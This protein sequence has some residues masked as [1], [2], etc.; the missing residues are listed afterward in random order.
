MTAVA[1]PPIE[2][3]ARPEHNQTGVNFRRPM[4][5]PKVKGAV[6]DFHCHLFA[7]RHADVWFESADHY[8]IDR[9]VTMTPLEE[10]VSLQ[11][12]FGHRL[13]FIAVPRWQDRTERWV[14]E[15]RLRIEAFYNLG[16]R[17]VK[18]H[19][20]PG[21]MNLRGHRLDSPVYKP[22]FRE[23]IDRKMAIMTHIGDPELWYAGKYSDASKFG[24]RDEHY[25]MWD[26]LLSEYAG[27]PW[28]GAHL[29]GNP[30]NFTRLQNLLDR[31]PNL[32]L[33]C[34][35][36]RWMSREV[37]AR[38][39]AAR[40]FFIRNQDRI[41]FGSDQVSG[42]DRGFDFLSS[43]FWVHRKLW[44]TAFIGQTPILDPDLPKDQQPALRGLALPDEVLQ[45]IYHDNATRLLDAIRMGW[46]EL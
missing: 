42:D 18:F 28:V 33:D 43:R 7:R 32:M 41:L 9:F 1:P 23:V 30:E 4:P 20:A 8:G 26:S 16:S 39:D 14:D 13:R 25:R 34:S 44:E 12:D 46:G 24:T 31:Y 15:W 40:E 37:S 36:T 35:A 29:G 6:I 5:R 21:T 17:M 38:R 19:A 22:L 27:V 3:P 11:R 45:K 10:V 2:A